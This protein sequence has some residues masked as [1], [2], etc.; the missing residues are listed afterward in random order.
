[1]GFEGLFFGRL[2][3][4]DKSKRAN[5]KNLEMIWRGSDDLKESSDLF[6]GVLPNGY[7]PPNSFCFDD[8]CGD[9][10]IVEDKASTEYNVER[11]VD[12][13]I[14]AINDQAQMYKTND[15]IHTMGS[16]FQYQNALT[17]YINLDRLIKHVHERNSSINVFYSTPTCYLKGKLKLNLYF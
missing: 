2:D 6:T 8:T 3:Y 14:K 17:W 9:E 12:E 10:P 13:Y 16:D 15:L 4:N 1:M 11:R 7:N 5:E